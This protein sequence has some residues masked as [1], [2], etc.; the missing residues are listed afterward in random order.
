MD[1][2]GNGV[3]TRSE[4]GWGSWDVSRLASRARGGDPRENPHPFRV[5]DCRG[6]SPLAP[7]ALRA[8]SLADA[9]R[10]ALAW[11]LP[12]NGKTRR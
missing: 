2:S 12:C 1:C 6:T 9:A 8:R 11:V 4:T 10:G 7:A 3:T 5:Y